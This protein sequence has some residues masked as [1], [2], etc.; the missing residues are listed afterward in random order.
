V[1]W[2]LLAAASVLVMLVPLLVYA[3]LQK[4]YV[5]GMV[6]WSLK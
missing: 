5:K 1:D 6:G 2:G 4:Q 3:V